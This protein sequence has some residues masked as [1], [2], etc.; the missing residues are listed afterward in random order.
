MY[1]LKSAADNLRGMTLRRPNLVGEISRQAADSH[2]FDFDY[3]QVE[4]R[5]VDPYLHRSAY[6][7]VPPTC[8]KKRLYHPSSLKE[9]HT[10]HLKTQ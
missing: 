3:L 7:T 10:H 1:D 4:K 6:I 5:Y 9:L 8:S 2:F